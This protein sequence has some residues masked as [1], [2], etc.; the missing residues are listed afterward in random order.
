MDIP[1]SHR[2]LPKKGNQT[3][4]IREKNPVLS[5]GGFESVTTKYLNMRILWKWWWCWW[6]WEIMWMSRLRN[7][8]N[9]LRAGGCHQGFDDK[10]M[11]MMI[12]MMTTTTTM[13]IMN[14]V[15]EDW[16]CLKIWN[17]AGNDDTQSY[18]MISAPRAWWPT[19][20]GTGFSKTHLTQW[21]NS[22]TRSLEWPFR[23]LESSKKL[24]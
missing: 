1:G 19:P 14:F 13:M 15:C 12:I 2:A 7:C 9:V 23:C 20:H 3:R 6:Y 24:I 11:I 22:W 21:R 16:G 18:I 10:V 4:L 17:Y 5:L 8:T